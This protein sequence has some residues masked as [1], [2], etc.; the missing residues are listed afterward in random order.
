MA[1]AVEAA[2]DGNDPLDDEAKAAVRAF[3][4]AHRLVEQAHDDVLVTYALGQLR[5]GAPE[6]RPARLPH[7]YRA[8]ADTT[9]G[10]AGACETLLPGMVA[11]GRLAGA[12]R[13]LSAAVMLLAPMLGPQI[14]AGVGQTPVHLATELQLVA[15]TADTAAGTLPAS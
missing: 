13:D 7:A 1:T 6:D 11:G 8:L 9:G 10:T 12:C 3:N 14:A 2:A 15:E 5:I 4:Q